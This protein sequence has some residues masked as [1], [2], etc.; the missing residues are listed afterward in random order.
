MADIKAVTMIEVGTQQLGTSP[1][2]FSYIL[3]LCTAIICKDLALS[4][5]KDSLFRNWGFHYKDMMVMR[6]SGLYNW[7]FLYWYD[8]IL[9][10][11]RDPAMV[12]K[13]NSFQNAHSP[14]L[15]V[16]NKGEIGN[17]FNCTKCD[18]S[19]IFITAMYYAISCYNGLCNKILQN[20]KEWNS[21][22]S[23]VATNFGYREWVYN[24]Y[25]MQTEIESPIDDTSVE[26]L[27]I[28]L[29]ILK[30]E[31]KPCRCWSYN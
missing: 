3:L 27:D 19:C 2:Y 29:T 11:R 31:S 14:C 15:I 26:L 30:L 20:Y 9:I 22:I 16:C 1:T 21:C 4:Q 25:W 6:P 28:I 23:N 17:V 10:L 12:L 18:L 5:Y 8:D 13:I 24:C 7:E